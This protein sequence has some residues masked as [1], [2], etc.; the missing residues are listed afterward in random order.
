MSTLLCKRVLLRV[1]AASALVPLL[2]ILGSVTAFAQS[3]NQDAFK[4]L[5]WRSIGPHRAGRVRAISGVPSQPSVFYMAQNN[6]GVWKT[7]DAGR[8]WFPIFD[9]Q[10]TGSIGALAVSESNPNVV[11]VGSGEGLHRPDLSIGDGLYKSTDAGKTWTHLGLRD[12][13]Q[14]AQIAVDPG[15]PDH[16]LVAVAGHPYGPNE[17]RGIFLST[18]GGRNFKKT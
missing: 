10:P 2:A 8:V 14:I 18:D 9:D 3:F 11:Y 16:L 17:E 6:G 15:N 13:Q 5:R 12:G 4:E 7:T 1:T